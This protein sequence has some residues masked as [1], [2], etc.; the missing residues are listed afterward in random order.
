MSGYSVNW[1]E[2][3]PSLDNVWSNLDKIDNYYRL[4]VATLIVMSYYKLHE[5]KKTPRD[6]ELELI[7]HNLNIGLIAVEWEK[8]EH[9]KKLVS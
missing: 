6:L 5:G 8:N 2:C 3:E 1:E 4:D 9:Y 7:E